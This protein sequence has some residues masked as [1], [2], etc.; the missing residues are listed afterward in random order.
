MDLF[1]YENDEDFQ[2]SFLFLL[3]SRFVISSTQGTG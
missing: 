2:Q 1:L 3:V